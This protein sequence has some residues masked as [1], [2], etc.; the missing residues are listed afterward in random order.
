MSELLLCR[1]PP[2]TT[3]QTK[4]DDETD[5]GLDVLADDTLKHSVIDTEADPNELSNSLGRQGVDL[6]TPLFSAGWLHT[7][8]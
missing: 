4:L 5:P 6:Q 2:L 8:W 1:P 7:G 3:K